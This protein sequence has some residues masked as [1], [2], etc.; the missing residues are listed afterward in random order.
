MRELSRLEANSFG[1]PMGSCGLASLPCSLLPSHPLAEAGC[2]LLLLSSGVY[3]V[4]SHCATSIAATCTA[5]DQCP[6]VPIINSGRG[7]LISIVRVVS[8]RPHSGYHIVGDYSSPPDMV[9]R[10]KPVEKG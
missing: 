6:S 5:S 1:F 3:P 7:N 10:L 8:S 2:S 4:A 9:A